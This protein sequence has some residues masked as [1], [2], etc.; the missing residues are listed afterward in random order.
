MSRPAIS[1]FDLDHTLFC[2]NSSTRFGAYLAKKRRITPFQAIGCAVDYI[3]HLALGM[4][5]RDLHER[6]F[7]RI[8]RGL[9]F[10][11][12]QKDV[13]TFLS[14]HWQD[15]IHPPA[16]ERLKAAQQQGHHTV[17]L[18]NS[19]QFL[20]RPI[21]ERFAVDEWHATEYGVDQDRNFSEI[22]CFIEGEDKA[23]LVLSIAAK[24]GLTVGDTVAFSDS[25]LDLPFLTA[26][27]QAVVVRPDRR[28]HQVAL[29]RKWE[30]LSE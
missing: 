25:Y 30:V 12:I 4:P 16:V 9:S 21:A 6:A 2:G 14:G 27:G 18:S 26:A 28:L 17:I 8:F 7:E 29:E 10:D 20:V 3:R 13:Q 19:P 5:L 23:S 24:L 1:L 11:M 22:S 15:L